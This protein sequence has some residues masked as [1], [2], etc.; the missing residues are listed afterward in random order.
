MEVRVE[1]TGVKDKNRESRGIK[2]EREKTA[3]GRTSRSLQPDGKGEKG[4][5]GGVWNDFL[6]HF[7]IFLDKTCLY[8]KPRPTVFLSG[9]SF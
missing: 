8:Y 3:L 7:Y 1:N 4:Q 6:S 2:E 9:I 5:H